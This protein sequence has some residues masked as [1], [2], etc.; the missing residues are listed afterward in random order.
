MLEELAGD[1]ELPRLILEYRSLAKLKSTYT[2]K[3][4]EQ[5]DPGT[6]RVHT[7]YH[8][9]VAATGRLHPP[10]PTCRTFPSAHRKAGA[11]AR[12]SLRHPAT[13]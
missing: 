8:Q 11:S 4:P 5:I 6:G 10:T 3:L 7:C 13:C 12:L 2:D 1:Y 9:A